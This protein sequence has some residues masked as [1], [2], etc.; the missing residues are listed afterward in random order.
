MSFGLGFGRNQFDINLCRVR[1]ESDSCRDTVFGEFSC[2]DTV[3]D[4]FDSFSETGITFAYEL[5]FRRSTTQ[6]VRLEKFYPVK[7]T[8]SVYGFSAVPVL[9]NSFG[10]IEFLAD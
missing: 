9:S 10:N 8:S 3:S 1:I 7:L 2:R 5:R 4:S 6:I